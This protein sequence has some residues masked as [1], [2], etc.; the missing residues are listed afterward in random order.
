[1]F[2]YRKRPKDLLRIFNSIRQ[3]MDSEC[4]ALFSF[5]GCDCLSDYQ[6]KH[7][8]RWHTRSFPNVFSFSKRVS[9]LLYF[10]GGTGFK[11]RTVRQ[12]MRWCSLGTEVSWMLLGADSGEAIAGRSHSP[13]RS[14]R[15]SW[16]NL[17]GCW[18]GFST[19]KLYSSLSHQPFVS[20]NG[21]SMADIFGKRWKS[22]LSSDWD[23]GFHDALVQ[24]AWEHR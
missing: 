3:R 15:G 20:K 1:M 18:K 17:K 4:M 7:F 11:V 2:F 9:F 16:E 19:K 12:V 24:A 14:Q 8:G 22:S 6:H 5:R 10:G 21:L 23:W 13:L